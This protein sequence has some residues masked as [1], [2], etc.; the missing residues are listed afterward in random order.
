[1]MVVTDEMAQRGI[2]NLGLQDGLGARAT[3]SAIYASMRQV[4]PDFCAMLRALDGAREKMRG[5]IEPDDV[6]L[7]DEIEAAIATG[8]RRAKTPKAVE[9]EASQS[10]DSVAG[11]S[12]TP[13]PQ[14]TGSRS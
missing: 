13:S 7:L 14:N 5:A 11:A 12:P 10:G 8:S 9:C 6:A 2:V 3:V 4:D 1:M